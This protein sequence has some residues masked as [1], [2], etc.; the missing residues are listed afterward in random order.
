MPPNCNLEEAVHI[1]NFTDAA[2]GVAGRMTLDAAAEACPHTMFLS[3][4][5]VLL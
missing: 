5:T 3:I 4:R 2:I 1:K